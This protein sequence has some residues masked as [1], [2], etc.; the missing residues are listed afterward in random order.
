MY[1]N[2]KLD[3]TECFGAGLSQFV[4]IMMS[5]IVKYTMIRCE[6]FELDNFPQSLLIY[7]KLL[8]ILDSYP[9]T[10]R[11]FS[12]PPLPW[13]GPWWLGQKNVIYPI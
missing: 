8:N 9:N 6:P 5:E 13:N 2:S 1:S 12:G 7:R 3:M 4:L 10:E 11:F